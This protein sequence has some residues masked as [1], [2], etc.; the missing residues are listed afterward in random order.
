MVTKQSL[1]VRGAMAL[2]GG[3]GG[4]GKTV[5]DSTGQWHSLV[6]V[7]AMLSSA[8]PRLQAVTVGLGIVWLVLCCS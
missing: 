6:V 3:D 2:L 8:A 4:G 5:F 7:M 1:I